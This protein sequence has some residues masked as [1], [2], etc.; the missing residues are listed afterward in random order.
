[1]IKLSLP[2]QFIL[3]EIIKMTKLTCF[4]L[5]VFA[6]F[7]LIA[8]GSDSTTTSVIESKSDIKV[9]KV[10]GERLEGLSREYSVTVQNLGNSDGRIMGWTLEL[11]D[12]RI[13]TDSW[14][15]LSK[16][17]TQYNY[18]YKYHE[19]YSDDKEYD[20]LTPN[21]KSRFLVFVGESLRM[22]NILISIV[23]VE[24]DGVVHT[25]VY[26]TTIR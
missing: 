25:V 1:V 6:V 26:F 21:E 18:I 19:Y 16:D 17:E 15:G 10:H 4:V 7:F 14:R 9:I 2:L 11:D 5:I 23:I 20:V 3:K 13:F 24:E 8:C 12:G 22:K